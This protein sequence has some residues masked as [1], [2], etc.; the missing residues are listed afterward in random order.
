MVVGGE[1]GAAI[2]VGVTIVLHIASG[3]WCAVLAAIQVAIITTHKARLLDDTLAEPLGGR[4]GHWECTS[5]LSV[6]V[7][8]GSHLVDLSDHVDGDGGLRRSGHGLWFS[9]VCVC[10]VVG[11]MG[12]RRRRRLDMLKPPSGER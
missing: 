4:C 9:V 8:L 11:V 2:A 5:D 10:C 3:L 1:V 12:R 7:S 6:C